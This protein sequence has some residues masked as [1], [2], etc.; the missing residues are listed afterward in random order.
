MNKLFASFLIFICFASIVSAHSGRTDSSGGHTNHST[1]SYH[2]HN[3]G[4]SSSG[5]YSNSYSGNCACPY[6]RASDGSLCGA[7]SAWS[8][9]GGASPICY[10]DSSSSS[11]SRQRLFDFNTRW[12]KI[13]G[14][15]YGTNGMTC[16]GFDGYEGTCSNGVSYWACGNQLC[17]SDNTTYSFPN[18]DCVRSSFGSYCCNDGYGSHA[19]TCR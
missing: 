5:S 14:N 7:R 11:S 8:R 19:A 10:T 9:S 15:L 17:G 18:T 3:S 6:D 12:Q 1:G 2:Y 4:T 13:G 16:S